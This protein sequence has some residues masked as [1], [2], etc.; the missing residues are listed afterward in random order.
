MPKM[1]TFFKLAL[2]EELQNRNKKDQ[3][4]YFKKIIDK[5]G[6][7]FGIT[8]EYLDNKYPVSELEYDLKKQKKNLDKNDIH[9]FR[10]KLYEESVNRCKLPR[11]ERCNARIGGTERPIVFYLAQES[12]WIYGEQCSR[13]RKSSSDLCG[14]HLQHLTNGRY[15]E[16]PPH[17][18]YE[19]FKYNISNMLL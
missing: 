8:Y 14:I 15:L 4:K 13:R 19:K 10:K 17:N 2:Q 6:E 9:K 18:K 7:E 12:K 3:Q 16:E 5:W 1:V 11:N